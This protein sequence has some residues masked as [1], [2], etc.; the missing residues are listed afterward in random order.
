MAGSTANLLIGKGV[1]SFDRYVNGLPTGMTDLGNAPNFSLTL[2]PETL[3]H[4][5]SR[6]GLKKRDLSV[7]VSVTLGG[8]FTL[9]EYEINN[10]ALALYGS[11]SGSTLN[12]LAETSVTGH[13]KFV[14]NPATG[15]AYQVDCW[16]V[17]LKPA[18]EISFISDE[19]S[20]IDFEFTVEDDSA[21]HPAEPYMKI[22]KLTES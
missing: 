20:K 11:V 16:K 19:W 2:S 8:K 5:S 10:L 3:D 12:A 6:E 18:G 9:E 14:G 22:T 7:V 21:N 4:F 15:P 13:L 1:L 17:T